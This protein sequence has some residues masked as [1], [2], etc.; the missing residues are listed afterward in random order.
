M[1]TVENI[2]SQHPPDNVTYSH[3]AKYSSSSKKPWVNNYLPINPRLNPPTYESTN[4]LLALDQYLPKQPFISELYTADPSERKR[5]QQLVYPLNPSKERHIQ[6][7]ADSFRDF[8]QNILLPAILAWD[9]SDFIERCQTSPPEVPKYHNKSVDHLFTWKLDGTM[10]TVAVQRTLDSSGIVKPYARNTDAFACVHEK[11]SPFAPLEST[12]IDAI[13][14]Y[15]R[16]ERNT[17]TV[18]LR[19][20]RFPT[21]VPARKFMVGAKR[22]SANITKDHKRFHVSPGS[23]VQNPVFKLHLLNDA[24]VR[25]YV[26]C[27]ATSC[28]HVDRTTWKNAD[29]PR[30]THPDVSSCEHEYKL[31]ASLMASAEKKK[32]DKLAMQ[33]AIAKAQKEEAAAK[34]IDHSAT[35]KGTYFKKASKDAYKTTGGHRPT[36]GPSSTKHK[37]TSYTNPAVTRNV[38]H[39]VQPTS[40]A[41]ELLKAAPAIT[42]FTT[43]SFEPRYYNDDYEIRRRIHCRETA[44]LSTDGHDGISLRMGRVPT[45]P[46]TRASHSR[47]ASGRCDSEALKRTAMLRCGVLYYIPALRR[48]MLLASIRRAHL[49][50]Q[51]LTYYPRHACYVLANTHVNNEPTLGVSIYEVGQYHGDYD[52]DEM[53]V[54]PVYNQESVA[55][56]ASWI[57]DMDEPFR[58]AISEHMSMNFAGHNDPNY[59]Y[60]SLTTV[61]M[62]D[63]ARGD[64]DTHFGKAARM[65]PALVRQTGTRFTNHLAEDNYIEESIRGMSDITKQQLMQGPIG[66]M[67]RMAKMASMCFV[68]VDSAL[69]AVIKDGL[70]H[71]ENSPSYQAGCPCLTAVSRICA[72]AQQSA[73]DSHRASVEGGGHTR[74]LPP[75]DMIADLF[76]G[77]LSTVVVLEGHLSVPSDM[78]WRAEIGADTV[79]ILTSEQLECFNTFDIIKGEF[80]YWSGRPLWKGMLNGDTTFH[81]PDGYHREFDIDAGRWY[82]KRGDGN[83]NRVAWDTV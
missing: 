73:L 61:S 16:R 50:T 79:C 64:A 17:F 52:G 48:A 6:S 27:Q 32:R 29:A 49:T 31:E 33:L 30:H 4:R 2:L 71:L 21:P 53:H 81:H 74:V 25:V 12:V 5:F 34:A 67:S 83:G 59:N 42:E 19:C 3:M 28:I 54:M 18:S 35:P 1:E 57:H 51:H 23:N 26:G 68:R 24:V 63:I 11:H 78:I 70:V 56:C 13:L 76:E 8:V 75:H 72:A 45:E 15:A 40:S 36:A 80:E 37:C 38:H 69:C 58:G 7:E 20:T 39:S 47:A 60:M 66:Y 82:W 10:G 41:V 77:S 55:E 9:E 46:D 22:L 44:A 14:V 43:R 65:K 62:A